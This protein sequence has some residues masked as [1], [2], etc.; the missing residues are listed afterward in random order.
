[1][2]A[3][4][5]IARK[6]DGKELSDSEISWFV[7]ELCGD[8][9][10]EGQ[11]AAFAMATLLKGMNLRE[12]VTLTKKMRDSGSTLQWNLSGPILD[13]HSTGG[14]GDSVSLILAPALAA[15]GAFVPMISGRG[16][17]H[18]GGT[19]DKFDAI[20]GY[21]TKP[22]IEKLQA[23]VANIGC[24]IV[25]QTEEIA[26]AD[27]RLYAVRDVTGTIESLDLIT[28]SIL[29][30]KLSAN[31]DALVL[32]IKCGNGSFMKNYEEARV[33]AKSLVDVSNALGC[34]AKA[35]IT[36]MNQPLSFSVGNALEMNDSV[37]ILL[38]ERSNIRLTSVVTTL[39]GLILNSVGLVKDEQEGQEKILKSLKS[40]LAAETFSKMVAA[41][42]GPIDFLENRSNYFSRAPV[43]EDIYTKVEGFVE[44]IDTRAIGL[45]VVE[46]GGGRKKIEDKIDYSVGFDNLLS[47]SSYVD[48]N[49]P[50]GTIHAP[51]QD[52]LNYEKERLI[53]A[54][55]IAERPI[56]SQDVIIESVT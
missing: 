22:S 27:K 1:M 44:D 33:L 49:I 41:L 31:L 43:V 37:E 5:V 50:I 8:N 12:R 13:K 55:K 53:K 48:I 23:V 34:K 17:G 6:R 38:G 35:V 15:N 3:Q 24:A 2:L 28:A 46:M 47:V 18:T 25:G 19:L 45:A 39:G 30:K 10:S 54:Y 56:E 42:G 40:G 52:I 14:V 9:L 7:S 11:V 21:N 32:D 4:E 16:L 51:N 29:S 26:P 36:D 20:P